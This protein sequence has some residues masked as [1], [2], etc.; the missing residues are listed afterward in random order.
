MGVA[1]AAQ[2]AR[3]CSASGTGGQNRGAMP[4]DWA[5]ARVGQCE[6]L[7]PK[8]RATAMVGKCGVVRWSVGGWEPVQSMGM[9]LGEVSVNRCARGSMGGYVGVGG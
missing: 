4:L 7:R 1:R 6:R 5:T 2:V 8:R 9:Y 3:T